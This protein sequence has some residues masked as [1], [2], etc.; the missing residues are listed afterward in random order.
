VTGVKKVISGG[1]V[2]A[3]IA[4][5]RAARKLGLQTGGWLPRG[6]KTAHG[7]RREYAKMYGC[8]E[9]DSE[10]YPPRTFANVRE[11]D[12][13]LRF[14]ISFR[15]PGEK[16]TMRAIRQ[17]GKPHYDVQIEYVPEH[18]QFITYASTGEVA[19]W[20]LDNNVAVLN[21]AGNAK[22]E[23]EELV[24]HILTQTLTGRPL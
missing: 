19:Q 21:V 8:Q 12:A 17:Y 23:I 14:A 24:E 11:S 2:G 4:A 22:P 15:S 18:D 13:T 9:H 5:L 7:A 6:F 16:C 20:L 1:Q 3:D 10:L